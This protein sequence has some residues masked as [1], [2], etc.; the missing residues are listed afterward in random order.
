MGRVKVEDVRLTYDTRITLRNNQIVHPL[1]QRFRARPGGGWWFGA[2]YSFAPGHST[3][4]SV[5]LI[6]ADRIAKQIGLED[7]VEIRGALY[8]A[9]DLAVVSERRTP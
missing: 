4:K 5:G 2:I 1:D 8:G 9:S 7:V 6:F 3:E